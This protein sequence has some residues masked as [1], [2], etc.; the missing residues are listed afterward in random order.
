[1][2]MWSNN[3]AATIGSLQEP[4]QSPRLQGLRGF[5]IDAFAHR[6]DSLASYQLFWVIF[7]VKISVGIYWRL[8]GFVWILWGSLGFEF[9]KDGSWD[10]MEINGV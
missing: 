1:M 2:A 10:F 8:M 6:R 7:F 9:N 5:G 4:S 3:S